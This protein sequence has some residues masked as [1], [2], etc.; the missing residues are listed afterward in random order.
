MRRSIDFRPLI[1]LGIVMG[2]GVIH[3]FS[4]NERA[5]LNFYYLPVVL[6]SWWLGR[7]R[8]VHAALLSCGIAFGIAFR[9]ET[10]LAGAEAEIWSRW[11]DFG[12]WGGFLILT[13]YIVGAL[14]DQKE[15]QFRELRSAYAGIL[16]IMG[17]FIDSVDRYTENHS[18]RVATISVTLA[19]RLALSRTEIEDIRVGAFLHDI[20]KVE[21]STDLLHKASGLTAAEYAEMQR[22]VDQGEQLVRSVGGILRRVIPLVAY[23]HEHFDGTGYKGLVGENIPLGARIIAVADAYDAIVSDRAYRQGRTHQEALHI[24][25]E[26][27]GKQFD[28]RVVEAFAQAYADPPQRIE[29]DD[30]RA[31]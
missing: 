2:I 28:P 3:F 9:N 12:T 14:H 30:R 19:E 17:K 31:A 27:S 13:G 1:L 5:L 7:H 25:Q 29:R 8:G 4:V 10:H 24:I 21:V 6:G 20:G 11:V 15:A 26:E 23:H 18:R 22:H 16:E